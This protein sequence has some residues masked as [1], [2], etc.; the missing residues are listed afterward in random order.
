[1]IDWKDPRRVDNIHLYMVDPHNLD[2]VIGEIKDVTLSGCSLTFG[3]DTDTRASGKIQFLDENYIKNSWIRIVHEVKKEGYK[4]ELGTFV[5]VSPG[6]EFHGERNSYTY[7]LQSVLW[8][9]SKDRC[10]SH[11]SIGAGSYA[12]DVFDRICHTCNRAYIH[13]SG[14]KNY[15]YTETVIYEM[16]DPYLDDI[17]DV[18]NISGNRLEVDGHGRILIN[19]FVSP[20]YITPTWTL[21]ADDER[22]LV[23]S[24]S[25][26]SSSTAY[27]ISGR[28][29]VT[30][31]KGDDEEIFAYSDVSNDSDFSTAKRG[32]TMAELYSVSDMVPA[33]KARAQELADEYLR[34]QLSSVV[35]YSMTSK[36]FP[37]MVGETLTFIYKGEA[38]LCLIKTID[39]INLSDMTMGLTLSEVA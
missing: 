20:R 10:P 36:Y 34:N 12:L 4:K 8:T 2:D 15:R 39:P 9:L 28:A 22:S 1:M 16:G 14:V 5:A 37:C 26:S 29:I 13:G 11:F 6:K 25:I 3:Y 24:A 17:K 21:N 19:P 35:E 33:T 27:D 32:Y 30:Y 18:A 31:Q 38:H 23:Q 7:D